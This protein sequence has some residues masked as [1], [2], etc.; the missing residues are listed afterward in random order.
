MFKRAFVLH[1]RIKFLCFPSC[2]HWGSALGGG[3]DVRCTQVGCL[4]KRAFA[5]HPRTEFLCF[6]SCPSRASALGGGKDVRCMQRR[7]ERFR[8]FRCGFQVCGRRKSGTPF[9]PR[10]LTN[11]L[12]GSGGISSMTLIAFN[13]INLIGGQKLLRP[14]FLREKS[15]S[16]GFLEPSRSSRFFMPPCHP[17]R[18]DRSF[19]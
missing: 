6:P 19:K 13:S 4:S 9:P 3:K 18:S 8:R 5:L 17:K 14:I 11:G 7:Y 10:V 15:Y 1:P 2:P 12:D 16:A